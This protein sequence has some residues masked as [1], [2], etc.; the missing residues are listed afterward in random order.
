MPRRPDPRAFQPLGDLALH[1]LVALGDGPLH[2]YAIIQDIEERSGG[3][4]TVRSG[5]LYVTLHKLHEEGLVEPAD[6]PPGVDARRRYHRLTPLG[7]DV[8][9]LEVER[10]RSLI[11]AAAGRRLAPAVDPAT[12]EDRP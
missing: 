10:L 8:V 5:T 1:V 2:G 12:A 3:R 4:S 7:R 11:R 6:A 9:R